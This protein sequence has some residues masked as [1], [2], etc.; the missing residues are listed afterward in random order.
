VSI[1]NC[2]L[3]R[4]CR[5]TYA[6]T[7]DHILDEIL[8]ARVR[9]GTARTRAKLTGRA[10]VARIVGRYRWV[11][12]NALVLTCQKR[13]ASNRWRRRARG[14][15][16]ACSVVFPPL[17]AKR[18]VRSWLAAGISDRTS[19]GGLTT[20]VRCD[21]C[22]VLRARCGVCETSAADVAQIL[23]ASQ[24]VWIA[25]AVACLSIALI[26][27]QLAWCADQCTRLRK[28]RVHFDRRV[29]P[30]LRKHGYDTSQQ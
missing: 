29:G 13:C 22:G 28:E 24:R 21:R 9:D 5:G 17:T 15:W 10:V 8:Y 1:T 30:S 23:N 12:G 18:S 20:A 4:W 7:A 25:R 27:A 26:S 3:A 6:T 16:R 14:W 2:T 11:A 19:R